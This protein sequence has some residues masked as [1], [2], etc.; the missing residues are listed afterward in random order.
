MVRLHHDVTRAVNYKLCC[1][2]HSIYDPY[3]NLIWTVIVFKFSQ[4][5]NDIIYTQHVYTIFRYWPFL[6]NVTQNIMDVYQN[7]IQFS[8]L[9]MKNV[10]LKVIKILKEYLSKCTYLP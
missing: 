3:C 7:S 1:I 2:L 8:L 10:T 4:I 9:T 5:N 6:R